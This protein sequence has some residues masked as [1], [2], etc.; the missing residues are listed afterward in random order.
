M[1]VKKCSNK[2]PGNALLNLLMGD[3][4][5]KLV[6]QAIPKDLDVKPDTVHPICV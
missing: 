1:L 6:A 4:A 2:V 3:M 5:D